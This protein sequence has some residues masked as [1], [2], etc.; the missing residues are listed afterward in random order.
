MP[1]GDLTTDDLAKLKEALDHARRFTSDPVYAANCMVEASATIASLRSDLAAAQ[2]ALHDGGTC[3]DAVRLAEVMRERD[4]ARA[5]RDAFDSGLAR[6]RGV[7]WEV[8]YRSEFFG[9]DVSVRFRTRSSARQYRRDLGVNHA[10]IV[11]VTT[12]AKA[13][14]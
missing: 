12:F 11:R 9:R 4:D 13:R 7:R 6:V 1:T 8:R 3:P 14:G 2:A 10:R 5:Q